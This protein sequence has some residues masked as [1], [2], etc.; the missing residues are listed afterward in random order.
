LNDWMAVLIATCGTIL[1]AAVSGLATYK[2][3]LIGFK[4]KQSQTKLRQ[5]LEDLQFMYE[6]ERH[7]LDRIATSSD[8]RF[9][10]LKQEIRSL[11]REKIGRSL[12]QGAEPSRL[13]KTIDSLMKEI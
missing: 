10:T 4:R 13:Q 7:C 12:S 9:A 11:V 5:A 2:A 6:V 1:G 3:A 8:K